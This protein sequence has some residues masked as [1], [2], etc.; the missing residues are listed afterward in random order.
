MN[1]VTLNPKQ[2]ATLLTATIK[3]THPVLIEGA[4]GV[5]KTDIVNQ[6]TTAADADMLTVYC[7]CS[8]P[9]DPKGMPA[10]WYQNYQDGTGQQVAD[11]IPFGYLQ[12]LIHTERPLVC[13]LDDVGGAAPAVQLSYMN[14]VH[15]RKTGDGTPIS[16]LVTFIAATNRRQDKAGV[17]GMLEPFKSRFTTIVE[18]EPDLDS[19]CQWALTENLPMEVISFVRFRPG[20]LNDFHPSADLVNS[21]S[22]RTVHNVAKLLALG[23]PVELEYP[24]IAGAAG[25]GF[26]G[27][28]LG[29]LKIFRSLPSP[30]A[31]LMSPDTHPVPEDPA[32]LFALTGALARKSSTTNF[33]A[34]TTYAARMPAEFSVCLVKDAIAQKP[35]LTVTKAF[36]SWATTHADILI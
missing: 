32:T 6:A 30:D 5:G 33:D 23:L 21:P 31:V 28:F 34:V 8:D 29:F 11:F 13:F 12:Q 15:A 18:L 27:E 19:W 14:L 3:A 26:A 7:A 17:S 16:P 24:T 9:T 2:L 36:V 25:E 4:P 10:T 35:E 20:L 22:P 1:H